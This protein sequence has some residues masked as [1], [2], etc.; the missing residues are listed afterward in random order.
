MWVCQGRP[1]FFPKGPGTGW[2]WA[3]ALFIAVQAMV[4]GIGLALFDDATGINIVYASRGLWVI[5][6]VV[7]FGKW[8]GNSE[9]RD[10][11]RGFLWRVAGTL[12]LSA[13]IVIAV[14]DRARVAAEL[15]P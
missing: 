10:Q 4:M 11:G 6:L 12:L 9:H 13:A 14:L 5:A 3:G 15:A 2:A 7:A 8:L 1:V